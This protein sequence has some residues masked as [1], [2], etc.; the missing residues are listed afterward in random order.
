MNVVVGI[1]HS[2]MRAPMRHAPVSTRDRENITVAEVPQE[3]VGMQV[4]VR[5]CI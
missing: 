2:K 3:I 4:A 5:W 1:L